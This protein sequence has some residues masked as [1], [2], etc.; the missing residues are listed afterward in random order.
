LTDRVVVDSSALV[1]LLV[2]AGPDGTWATGTFTG[3][4][5]LAPHL[6]MFE[7][8]SVL[9]RHMSAGLI[10]ADQAVQAHAD[11]VD[12]SIE[13]WPYGPWLRR[14]NAVTVNGGFP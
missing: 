1:A 6:V 2:D 12:L 13:L 9:R 7:T 11:L 4:D 5:L 3:S 10:S 8:A 14:V